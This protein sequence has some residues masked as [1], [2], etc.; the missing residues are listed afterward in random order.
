[1]AAARRNNFA[2]M[3]PLLVPVVGQCRLTQLDPRL[4]AL[5]ISA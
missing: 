1:M 3:D 4:T 2:I 5:G